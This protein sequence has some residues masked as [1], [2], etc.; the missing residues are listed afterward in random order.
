MHSL[1]VDGIWTSLMDLFD[2][3]ISLQPE[4]CL[5]EKPSQASVAGSNNFVA[6]KALSLSSMREWK[7]LDL[8]KREAQASPSNIDLGA[9]RSAQS[10]Y[11]LG[12]QFTGSDD[13]L[14]L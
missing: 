2:G 6:I 3:F 8:F 7:R 12:N 10:W 9:V 14:R 11:P 4:V 5:P 13:C 1:R